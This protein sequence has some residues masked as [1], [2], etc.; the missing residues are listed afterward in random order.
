MNS[1]LIPH[2]TNDKFVEVMRSIELFIA[3]I[4]VTSVIAI[5]CV[6]IA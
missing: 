5:V 1:H 3:I 6:S 2:L 4:L